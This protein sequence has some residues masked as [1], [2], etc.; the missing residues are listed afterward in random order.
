M[1]YK[2]QIATGALAF[3]L[4]VGGSYAG[5]VVPQE[6]GSKILDK[7][8]Q[9]QN[10]SS[11]N[12][13]V[14]Q[15]NNAV[16]IISSIN[17]L[18]FTLDIKNLKTKNTVSIDVKTDANTLYIK[19]GIK[20]IASDLVAG[21]KVIVVGTLDKTTNIITAKKVKIATKVAGVGFSNKG[22]KNKS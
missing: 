4:L 11:K 16:G 6:L 10:K 13:K 1:K 14:V 2:K 3:S 7:I 8:Y 19:N 5:A 18:G 12:F 22:I 9:K 15:N 20:T 21:G 17:G